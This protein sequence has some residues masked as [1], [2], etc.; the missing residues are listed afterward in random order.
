MPA[1]AEVLVLA[2]FSFNFDTNHHNPTSILVHWLV[3]IKDKAK[4]KVIR[5]AIKVT[6]DDFFWKNNLTFPSL[7]KIHILFGK[8]KDR[9]NIEKETRLAKLFLSSD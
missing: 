3:P 6:H 1:L 5:I 7:Q 2:E 4:A 9:I 8:K